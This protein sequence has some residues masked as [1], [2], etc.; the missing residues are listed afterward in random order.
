MLQGAALVDGVRMKSMDGLVRRATSLESERWDV[1]D[2]RGVHND[3][4]SLGGGRQCV[5]MDGRGG[6]KERTCMPGEERTRLWKIYGLHFLFVWNT[7]G[8]EFASVSQSQKFGLFID[9]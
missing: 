9:Q 8:Y 6:V 7:R 4:A 3:L 5:D 2:A 1:D